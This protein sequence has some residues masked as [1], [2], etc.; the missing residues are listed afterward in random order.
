MR[1]LTA[2]SIPQSLFALIVIFRPFLIFWGRVVKCVHHHK[3]VVAQKHFDI[4]HRHDLTEDFDAVGVAVY[5]ISKDI[6]RVLRLQV[7]LLHD[8]IKAPLLPMD[9]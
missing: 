3:F 5:H 8:G 7:D 4:R 1:D 2:V 6:D 9:I